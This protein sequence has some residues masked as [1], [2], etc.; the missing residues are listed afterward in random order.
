MKK[1]TIFALISFLFASTFATADEVNIFNACLHEGVL[2]LR[3]HLVLEP[4]EVLEWDRW[5]WLILALEGRK[6][7]RYHSLPFEQRRDDSEIG[8]GGKQHGLARLFRC[9]MHTLR[10]SSWCG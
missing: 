6:A 8:H 9:T 5:R 10:S 1:I 7:H 4:L 2:I 3:G